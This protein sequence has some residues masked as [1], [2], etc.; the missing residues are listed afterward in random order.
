MDDLFLGIHH[1]FV[2]IQ[3]T[4]QVKKITFLQVKKITFLDLKFFSGDS[5]T[6][7]WAIC[8]IR[9]IQDGKR[10]SGSDQGGSNRIF[11]GLKI[12]RLHLRYGEMQGVS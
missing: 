3:F 4:A 1:L 7:Q 8:L 2:R 11:L 9:E 5:F 12:S 10:K 6:F